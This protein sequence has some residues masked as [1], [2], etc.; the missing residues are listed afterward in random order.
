MSQSEHP[1]TP[2]EASA[3]ADQRPSLLDLWHRHPQL[4]GPHLFEDPSIDPIT[5]LYAFRGFP[6]TQH[7]FDA[8]L[9][10]INRLAG[11]HYSQADLSG[12]CIA[13]ADD[14]LASSV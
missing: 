6:V 8:L 7:E 3:R 13:P 10:T 12:V 1:I 4:R 9:A 11:T 14:E 5:I 2:D